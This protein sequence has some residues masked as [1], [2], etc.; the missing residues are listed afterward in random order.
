MKSLRFSLTIVLALL[1]QFTYSQI[2]SVPQSAKDNFTKQ[3]PAAQNVDW[4]NDVVNV[5]VHF[6]LDGEK[7]NA[8]YSN[9]GIWKNTFQNSSFAK[10]PAAVQDGFSKSKYADREVADVKIIYLPANVIQYRI[11]AEK[12]DVEKKYLYLD[13]AG[14]LLRDSITL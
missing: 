10:L 3:Y 6:T 9:K 14:K 2:T 1:F 8:E 11:K 7:M 13:E 4:D 5:N 12:N